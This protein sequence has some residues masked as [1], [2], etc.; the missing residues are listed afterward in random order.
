[1]AAYGAI[2]AVP[3][4]YAGKRDR[5]RPVGLRRRG[6]AHSLLHLHADTSPPKERDRQRREAPAGADGTV[7]RGRPD[8]AAIELRVPA[9]LP[10]RPGA[11]DRSP[12]ATFAATSSSPTTT[13][14]RASSRPM[15]HR[16]FQRV[17]VGRAKRLRGVLV[18][19]ELLRGRVA[20]GIAARVTTPLP[21]VA[22]LCGDKPQRRAEGRRGGRLGGPLRAC[23]W[24]SRCCS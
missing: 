16:R 19:Q 8:A 1:M 10:A 18:R 3:A 13:C 11:R 15:P 23:R 12:G 2:V 6:P 14:R 5:A 22:S 4:Y 7:R 21:D 24:R 17:A 20:P 9:R